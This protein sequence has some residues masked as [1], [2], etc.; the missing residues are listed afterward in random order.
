MIQLTLKTLWNQRRKNGWILIEMILVGFF[1][2]K[3]VGGIFLTEYTAHISPGYN[4]RGAMH[5]ELKECGND[6]DR[7]NPAADNDSAR[8]DNL[9]QIINT[10]RECPEVTS[11]FMLEQIS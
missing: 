9:R 4:E 2:W 6:H 10:I 3:A 1:L 8:M 7:Y 11:F 5:I